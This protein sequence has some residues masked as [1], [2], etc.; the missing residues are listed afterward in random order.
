M[1]RGSV[2]RAPRALSSYAARPGEASRCFS[3]GSTSCF[4]SRSEFCARPRFGAVVEAEHQQH[5]EAADSW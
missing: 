3:R 2:E 5:A 1:T 4:Q